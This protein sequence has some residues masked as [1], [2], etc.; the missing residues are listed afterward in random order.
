LLLFYRTLAS[1]MDFVGHISVAGKLAEISPVG[2]W[3]AAMPKNEWP[4][5]DDSVREAITKHWQ[6][7]YGDRRQELVFIGTDIDKETIKNRLDA[8]LLTKDEYALGPDAWASFNDPIHA[9]QVREE[10]AILE[11]A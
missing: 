9:W 6:D 2:K 11:D 4:L 5:E 8:C 1:R 7:P 10:Q 3:W